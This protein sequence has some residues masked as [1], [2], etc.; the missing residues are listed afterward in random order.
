MTTTLKIPPALNWDSEQ[1]FQLCQTNPDLNLE[2]SAEGELLIMPPTGGETGRANALLITRLVTWNESAGLGVVFDSSTCFRLPQ[3]G[4]RSPD[5]AWIQAERWNG[6][7]PE[8]RRRFPPLCP[9]FVIEL[10][11]PSDRAPLT[12]EKMA[13]FLAS[14]LRLGWLIDPQVKQVEIYRPDQAVE[15]LAEPAE[16]SGEAI[17]PG[18]TLNLA[19]LWR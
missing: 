16:L 13:E 8:E 10:L 2:R 1:F 4:D 3:G 11:S 15:I 19:W 6:L 12:R 18:F 5:V 7:T 14:G 17:L 9:D